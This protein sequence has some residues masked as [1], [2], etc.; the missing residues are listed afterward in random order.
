MRQRR[1]HFGDAEDETQIHDGDDDAR[2]QQAAPAAGGE[3]EVP[4][5]EVAGDDRADAERPQR[6]HARI[7]LQ[8]SLLEVTCVSLGIADAAIFGCHW[9]SLPVAHGAQALVATR[10]RCRAASDI[11]AA[12]CSTSPGDLPTQSDLLICD[13]I[14]ADFDH[15]SKE[16]PALRRED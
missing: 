6:P 10:C 11:A 9:F 14:V 3:A 15:R 16:D 1:R 7:T 4:P 8:P 5:G 13:E 12:C 2:H